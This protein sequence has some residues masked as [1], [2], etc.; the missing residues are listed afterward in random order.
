MNFEKHIYIIEVKEGHL[1]TFGHMNNAT[2]L[3]ILEEARWDFIT[4]RGYGFKKIHETGL[5]PII[6]EINMK[7]VK[8]LR[9]REEIS[10]ESQAISY[11]K[12]IGHLR[13][14]IYNQKKELC[15]ESK[16]T[17]GFFDT[18]ERKLVMPSADWLHA[19]GAKS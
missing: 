8:E 12:K 13:Q 5:G 7:F 9:L 3:Q 14:D 15:F 1:D 10:I 16:F 11:D 18:R 4:S 6:L 17:F 19:I 2:Y